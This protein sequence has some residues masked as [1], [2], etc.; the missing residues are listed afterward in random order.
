MPQRKA[1]AI[2]RHQSRGLPQTLPSWMDQ[3]ACA[4]HDDPDLWFPE[5]GDE[6]REQEA[7]RICGECPVRSACLTYVL[8][9]PMQ[10]GIW[11]GTTEGERR[12]QLKAR[13]AS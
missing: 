2:L 10:P 4:G 11:G 1:G 13:P 5:R 8:S 6:D 7:L 3:A 9:L 12:S